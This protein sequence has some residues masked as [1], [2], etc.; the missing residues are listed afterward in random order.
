[1]IKL[2][3]FIFIPILLFSQT[4]EE[5]Y[6]FEEGKKI[7][8]QTCISCHGIDGNTN[9]EMQLIVKPRTLVKTILTK[10]QSFKIIKE[11][12]HF[13]GARADIMPSFKY[14]YSDDEIKA[15]AF[16]ISKEFNSHRDD[17]VK[18]LLEESKTKIISDKKL[19]KDGHKIFKRNCSLCHG[20]NGDGKSAYI[21]KSKKNDNFIYPYNLTRTL[22]TETQI[23]LYAKYGG[24]FWGAD[25]TDMPS[26]KKKYNDEKLKSVARYVHLKIK[27]IQK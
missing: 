5:K 23:F 4:L 8:Q 16:Y 24:H 10:E 19:L 22:L 18:K 3:F 27:K 21:E 12:A 2:I 1:M 7:Y 13:W 15:I 26:W 17:K 11:G 14:I 20:I 25:K 9:K 6:M